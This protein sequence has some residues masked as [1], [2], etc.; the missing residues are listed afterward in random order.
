MSKTSEYQWLHVE[1]AA[2]NAMPDTTS[3][4]LQAKV[5]TLNGL[6]QTLIGFS[7]TTFDQLRQTKRFQILLRDKCVM[8]Q[9]NYTQNMKH[10]WYLA[11][12]SPTSKCKLHIARCVF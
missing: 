11:N 2:E 12:W 1:I 5:K 8:F 3:A 6:F 10:V 9:K 7:D 4:H